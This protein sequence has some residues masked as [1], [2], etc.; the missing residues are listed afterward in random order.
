MAAYLYR[1]DQCDVTDKKALE[2]FRAK[3]LEWL[4]W[5]VNDDVHAIWPQLSSALWDDVAF[6]TLAEIANGLGSS[7]LHN[8]LLAEALING[9][10]ARQAL[11]V[12][13]MLDDRKDVISL[14]RLIKDIERNL[15]LFTRENYVCFDGLPYD[16]EAVKHQ[17]ML[18]NLRNGPGP[19]WG[20]RE[21]SKAHWPSEALHA[22]FDGLCGRLR[23]PRSRTDRMSRKV[24]TILREWLDQSGAEDLATWSDKMLAHAA[25]ARSR[26]RVDIGQIELTL[27]KVSVAHRAF[28]R[29]AE[30]IGGYVLSDSAHGGA[31]P[32]PQFNQFQGLDAPVS[33]N[34]QTQALHDLWYKLS[35]D[36]DQWLKDAGKELASCGALVTSFF[37]F[38]GFAIQ[39]SE[40]RVVKNEISGAC[41]GPEKGCI[42]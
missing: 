17:A 3:R 8:T 12:R 13:R 22:A 40:F 15:A 23:K 4:D 41:E 30:A 26:D 9:Y 42:A 16:F 7:A 35:K 29:V 18:E 14:H 6:R 38:H 33:K 1:T 19:Y 5:L 10:Y 27:E 24:I 39:R 11:L 32:T 36:R 34:G 2:R 31:V 28:V 20:A 25:D 21:G 37:I